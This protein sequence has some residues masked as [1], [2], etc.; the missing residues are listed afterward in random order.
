MFKTDLKRLLWSWLYNIWISVLSVP[1]TIKV[2]ISNPA[3]GEVYSI[4][5]YVINLSVTWGRLL[6]FCRYSCFLHKYNW[7]PRYHWI[8]FE[9]GVKHHSHN[10]NPN[11]C[12]ALLLLNKFKWWLKD[13]I[14][15]PWSLLYPP[16]RSCRWYTGFTMSVRPSVDKSYVVR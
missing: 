16:Q 5:L 9:S 10:P 6:V 7:L 8:I 4:Q 15:A 2:V 14:Q 12:M 13:G 3:Q 11:R 1:I